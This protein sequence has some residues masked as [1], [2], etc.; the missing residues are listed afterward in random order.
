MRWLLVEDARRILPEV[1]EAMGQYTLGELR[2]RGMEVRLGTRLQSAVG[3]HIGLSDGTELDANTLVWTAGVKPNALLARTGCRS[4]TAVDL[5]RL[6]PCRW[7]AS[8]TP[9]R[10][11]TAPLCRT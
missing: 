11:G 4:T 9:G 5:G 10:R 3:G 7:K 6:R 8:P 1:G 2:R